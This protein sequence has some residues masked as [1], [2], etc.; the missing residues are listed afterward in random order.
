MHTKDKVSALR[1][2][3]RRPNLFHFQVGWHMSHEL[4]VFRQE[5][6]N[7]HSPGEMLQIYY[8]LHTPVALHLM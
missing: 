3:W 7:L 5:S 4:V 6:H 1:L 2:T 8:Y